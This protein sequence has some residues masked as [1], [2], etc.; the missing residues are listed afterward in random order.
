MFCFTIRDVL[1]LTVIAAFAVAWGIDH[2]RL[3]KRLEESEAREQLRRAEVE[4][5]PAQAMLHRTMELTLSA[6][7][8]QIKDHHVAK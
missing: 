6:K 5:A 4:E 7:I 2:V 8:K 3:A 1:L